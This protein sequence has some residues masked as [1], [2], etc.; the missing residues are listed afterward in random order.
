MTTTTARQATVGSIIL[1]FITKV[2]KKVDD[3]DHTSPTPSITTSFTALEHHELTTSAGLAMV[4]N[5][6]SSSSSGFPSFCHGLVA[7]LHHTSDVDGV[8]LV[9]TKSGLYLPAA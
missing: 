1:V 8:I 2:F 5:S 7:A 6:S 4:M 9:I 3:L